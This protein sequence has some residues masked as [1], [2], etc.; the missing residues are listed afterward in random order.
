[1]VDP[2][3]ADAIQIPDYLS[4]LFP[5]LSEEE[6]TAAAAIYAGLGAP[7]DQAISIIGEGVYYY[8]HSLAF[9]VLTCVV[10]S[11]IYLPI[12]L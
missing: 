12:I 9:S 7:F 5:K 3:T 1:M 8:T 10:V 2:S 6:R 11:F 4:N